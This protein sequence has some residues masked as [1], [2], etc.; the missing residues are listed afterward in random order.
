MIISKSSINFCL[1]GTPKDK[2]KQYN[3]RKI[4]IHIE[5]D[6]DRKEGSKLQTE[7]S[8]YVLPNLQ[9]M[10]ANLPLVPKHFPPLVNTIQLI[11]KD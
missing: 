4:N 6:H 7:P 9:P 11:M 5:D 10:S 8:K 1:Q 3:E 2:R